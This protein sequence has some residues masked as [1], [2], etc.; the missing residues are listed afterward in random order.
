[1]PR[2]TPS[3]Q[4]AKIPQNIIKQFVNYSYVLY[5]VNYTYYLNIMLFTLISILSGG[6]ILSLLKSDIKKFCEATE[7]KEIRLNANILGLV[8]LIRGCNA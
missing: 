8:E 6:G 3:R 2:S 7:T 5:L 1:M 4:A